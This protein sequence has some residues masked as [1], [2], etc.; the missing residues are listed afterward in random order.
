MNDFRSRT[1][2]AFDDTM[3]CLWIW[4]SGAWIGYQME[5]MTVLDIPPGL[6]LP[7]GLGWALGMDLRQAL[8]YGRAPSEF[9]LFSFRFV[10]FVLLEL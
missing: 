7:A 10:S 8:E 5:M 6:G 9:G 3:P 2:A 1:D 4:V